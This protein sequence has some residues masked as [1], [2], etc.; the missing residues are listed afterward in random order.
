MLDR[1]SRANVSELST[2][3][4]CPPVIRN[5]PAI[6]AVLAYAPLGGLT[7]LL[8]ILQDAL[9]LITLHL[10]LCHVLAST[11]CRWQISSL[12][13]LWNLFRGELLLVRPGE[14]A[15]IDSR[16]TVERSQTTDRLVRVRRGSALPRHLALHRLHL[17]LAHCGYIRRPLCAS[18]PL[19]QAGSAFLTLRSASRPF[20]WTAHSTSLS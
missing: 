8:A 15:V 11:L 16:Q 4:I 6:L 17:P 9:G 5:L 13:G 14:E 2:A 10:R 19:Q 20:S 18:E 3:T 7:L 12:G 1:S